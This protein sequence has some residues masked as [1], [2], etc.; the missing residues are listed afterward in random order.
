MDSVNVPTYVRALYPCISRKNCGYGLTMCP[1][2]NDPM[3]S[4]SNPYP[5]SIAQA[6]QRPLGPLT[7]KDLLAP[8]PNRA[9][10]LAF[11]TPQDKPT[12]VWRVPFSTTRR[13]YHSPLSPAIAGSPC[14]WERHQPVATARQASAFR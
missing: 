12:I 6:S 11:A 8:S 14:E 4:A 13:L 5:K 10:P 9:G 7:E 1:W 2:P 3:V